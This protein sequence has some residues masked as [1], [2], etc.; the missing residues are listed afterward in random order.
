WRCCMRTR[1]DTAIRMPAS[2]DTQQKVVTVIVPNWNGMRWLAGCFTA[3]SRQHARFA[4]IVVDNAS[5]DGSVA[6]IKQCYPQYEVITLE[7]TTGFAH[8]VNIGVQHAS[9]PYVLVLNTDTELYPDCLARLLVRIQTSSRNVASISP[10]ILR[11]DD[12][13]RI[14]DAGDELSWYGAA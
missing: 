8:A 6:F 2:S 5:S 11:L 7:P 3:L 10:Q 9:T 13:Q 14:D 1:I 4:T 12:P